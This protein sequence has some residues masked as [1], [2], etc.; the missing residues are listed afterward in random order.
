M[1]FN[2]SNF[3]HWNTSNQ[4]LH[5]VNIGIDNFYYTWYHINY[6]HIGKV[7]QNNH[8]SDEQS[9]AECSGNQA[10]NSPVNSFTILLKDFASDT[11]FG[12]ISKTTLSDGNIRRFCWLLI[13]ITCYTFTIKY[14]MDAVETYLNKPIKTSI[15]IKFAKVCWG[16]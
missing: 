3:L 7:S 6:Q 15:D 2:V 16:F 14:C 4:W 12:G 9:P 13:S 5:R 1:K 10:A 11:S 8:P